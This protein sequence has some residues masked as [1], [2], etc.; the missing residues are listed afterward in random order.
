MPIRHGQNSARFE[1]RGVRARVIASFPFGLDRIFLTPCSYAFSIRALRASVAQWAF[2]HGRV[3]SRAGGS[4]SNPGAHR[5]AHR[6]ST[7]QHCAAS[8]DAKW[9]YDV[10]ARASLGRAE[11]RRALGRLTAPPPTSRRSAERSF[12]RARRRACPPRR[13]S[14]RAPR[15]SS[16]P[17]PPSA[18]SVD[19]HS[20][21]A[22]SRRGPRPRSA[23][24]R[25]RSVRW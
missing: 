8:F 16:R 14:R 6:E 2:S 15:G 21:R 20:R 23:A 3:S 11:L 24:P 12:T 19:R 1:D 5:E 4:H 10:L 7:P 22:N 25:A 13:R 17:P 18:R 9:N